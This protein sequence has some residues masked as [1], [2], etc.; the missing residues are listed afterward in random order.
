MPFTLDSSIHELHGV[1]DVG[2]R[3]L[4]SLDIKTIRDLLYHIPFRYEDFRT[5][6][7][8]DQIEPNESVTLRATVQSITKFSTRRGL[9]MI[10]AV[11][12]DETGKI[13]VVWFNQQ[14][15][16]LT[17]KKGSEWYFT[18]KVTVYN[19]KNTLNSPSTESVEHDEQLHSG[20][21]V[22]IYSETAGL[23]S[24]MLRRY[25]ADSLSSLEHINDPLSLELRESKQLPSL[26]ETLR[27]LHFPE[28]VEG[29]EKYTHRLAFEEV[30]T[31]LVA[32]KKRKEEL[33]H[34]RVPKK[35]FLT[36][37]QKKQFENSLPFN[38]SPT[39]TSAL[40]DLSLDLLQPYPAR[41]LI[42]GEVGSGKTI[43]A[44]FA[45][46][47]A[48]Q[49]GVQSVFIAPTQIL[50]HQHFQ[51]LSP[52]FEKLHIPVQIVAGDH[53]YES[54]APNTIFIGT[55]ALFEHAKTI[56]PAVVVIDEEHRFGVAQRETFWKA[57]KKP[58][59]FTMT[60]TPIPRTVAQTVLADQDVS[61]LDEI[62][63][64]K[65]QT[66]TKVVD[67]KN[68]QKAYAWIAHHLDKGAQA[69]VVCPFIDQSELEDLA[70]IKSAE[71]T[72]LSIQ[73]VFPKHRVAMLHGKTPKD[74]REKILNNMRT[75]KLDILVATP[76]IEVGIDIPNASI[77][78]IEG[79]ERF[80]LAQLHQL[81]GRVGRA[82]QLAYCLLFP[83]EGI[84][85]TRRLRILEKETNG[86]ILAE[87]DLKLRGTGELLGT[88][89]H[90]FDTLKFASWFDEELIKECK[91]ALRNER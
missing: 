51:T 62:P 77:M 55:H 22:P 61:Y 48:A 29:L 19:G 13:P 21:L 86:N 18:G 34:I 17:L 43:V 10:K 56:K 25:I 38:L 40:L 2:A 57:I 87:Q 90:G 85:T 30:Y 35:L 63:E 79:A 37:D 59:V 60:A 41:R 24:R 72:V 91:K 44:A 47:A 76:I 14:Y 5:Q 31:L 28:T 83:S 81:R 50:A 69:F 1:G 70:N 8:I 27:S 82:G 7:T 39:Q 67:E 78:V 49:N 16:L 58:H 64:K 4:E 73:K 84:E 9:V 53:Q 54:A 68:R 3:K 75:G 65:K 11:I 33:K 42:Q 15:L 26:N 71:K 45:L 32:A 6:K 74:Q 12:T 52:I 20:R 89:Q 88:R 46:F 66:I 36:T 23:S 80:G